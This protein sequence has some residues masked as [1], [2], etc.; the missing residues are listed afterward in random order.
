MRVLYCVVVVGAGERC[1]H[2]KVQDGLRK[3][4]SGCETGVVDVGGHNSLGRAGS[5]TYTLWGQALAPC[6][7]CRTC[8]GAS[9]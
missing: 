2:V 6:Q 9:G 3:V 8:V 4:G 1:G 5:H 7:G